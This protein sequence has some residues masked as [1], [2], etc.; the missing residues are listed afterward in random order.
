MLA[1]FDMS[2]INIQRY[3]DALLKTYSDP[4]LAIVDDPHLFFNADQENVKSICSAGYSIDDL[5]AMFTT[6]GVKAVLISGF[7]PADLR[8]IIAANNCELPLIYKMHGLYIPHMKR[9][10][11]FFTQNFKKS[12]RTLSYLFNIGAK[13]RSVLVPIGIL[14]SFLFGASR[15]GW[16]AHPLLKI[17]HA[18]VWSNYWVDWHKVHWFLNP[19]RWHLIGNPDSIK[20]RQFTLSPEHVCYIY[21]TL[22]EDGRISPSVMN[23]FYEN[24]HKWSLK[25]GQKIVVKWHPRGNN[26]HRVMLES[27]GF[28]I[29]EDWPLTDKYI[30]HYSSLMGLVPILNGRVIACE[31]VGHKVPESIK[32]ISSWLVPVGGEIPIGNS[33]ENDLAKQLYSN[34]EFFFG[35]LYNQDFENDLIREILHD[36]HLKRRK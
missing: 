11:N 31:L 17:D 32:N 5:E 10:I 6:Y 29:T 19:A 4:I 30:G 26:C 3:N 21:Q 35:S 16:A 28:E 15:S 13:T 25:T 14:F 1:I 23:K 33:M 2:S 9:S 20:F 24:L 7:R 34:A 18:L 12:I 8:V 36:S 22:V 27:L